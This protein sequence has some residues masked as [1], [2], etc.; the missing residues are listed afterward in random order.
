[1][2]E[3]QRLSHVG[4]TVIDD[5]RAR[6]ARGEGEPRALLQD[7]GQ[8]PPGQVGGVEAEIKVRPGGGYFA[9][10]G[11]GGPGR[12]QALRQGHRVFLEPARH[13]EAGKGQVGLG[14]ILG[15]LEARLQLLRRQG[16][17]AA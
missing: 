11:G 7:P 3:S 4:G 5:H 14:R 13:P 6:T 9:D 17:E 16:E 10:Q 8:G 15:H 12:G 2:V 1:M